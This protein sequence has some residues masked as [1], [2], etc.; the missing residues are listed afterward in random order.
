MQK[1]TNI[2]WEYM[3][4]EID[5]IIE[6]NPTKII[7]LDWQLLPLTKFFNMCDY[8]ILLDIPYE[9]RKERTLKRDNISESKFDER[10]KASITY[11]KDDF[12][13]II[14]NSNI[15]NIRKMVKKI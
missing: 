12:D 10:E 9:I 6:N 5:N 8:K 2:T 14:K 15:I 4:K 13:S 1:L 7:V 11:Q 3:E